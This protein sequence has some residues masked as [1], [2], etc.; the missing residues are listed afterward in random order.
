MS[1]KK[2][3]QLTDR[4]HDRVNLSVSW[5]PTMLYN[6]QIVLTLTVYF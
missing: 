6:K 2:I 1:M 5:C 4:E 3:Q